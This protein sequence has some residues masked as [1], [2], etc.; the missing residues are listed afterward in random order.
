MPYLRAL[1]FT[2]IV[3][4]LTY[5][6]LSNNEA[7][8]PTTAFRMIVV[9]FVQVFIGYCLGYYCEKPLPLA[10]RGHWE[11]VLGASYRIVATDPKTKKE[12][13]RMWDVPIEKLSYM[14]AKLRVA[15]AQQ[16][17]AQVA[18]NVTCKLKD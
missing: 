11:E 18:I 2:S 14:E 6:G 1:L 15:C 3:A 9:T 16:G 5:V 7:A 13:G 17:Y 4:G 12:I 8:L 10:R